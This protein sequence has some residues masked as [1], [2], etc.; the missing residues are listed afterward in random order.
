MKQHIEQLIHA[1]LK[2]LQQDGELQTIPASVQVDAT[3]DKQHGDYASNIAMILAKQMQKKPRE[4]AE[5]LIQV[6][7]VT[8]YIQKVD[9]AGPGFI[10]FYL[11]ANA[12]NSI[13]TK[14]LKEKEGAR[15][16]KNKKH[17]KQHI[18]FTHGASHPCVCIRHPWR[19]SV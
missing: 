16:E 15:N 4:I 8:G 5:R 10:N 7:P 9:I 12:L 18:H 6:L 13:V 14:I 11:T 17:A 19:M 2:K 1:A 3:K